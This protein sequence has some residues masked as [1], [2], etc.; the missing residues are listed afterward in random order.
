MSII[1]I[2]YYYS[3]NL[4]PYHLIMIVRIKLQEMDKFNKIKIK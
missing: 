1:N 4:I 2:K 3:W